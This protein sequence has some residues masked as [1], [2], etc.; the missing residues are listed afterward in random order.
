LV[1]VAISETFSFTDYVVSYILSL[2]VYN[3]DPNLSFATPTTSKAL[4]FADLFIFNVLS[5]IVSIDV[6]FSLA[7]LVVSEAFYF[8]SSKIEPTFSFVFLTFF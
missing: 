8:V 1:V 3:V 4:S 5:F 6:A 7:I 2:V